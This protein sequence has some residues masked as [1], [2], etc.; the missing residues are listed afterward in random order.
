MAKLCEVCHQSYPDDQ[1]T[2]PHCGAESKSKESID[3]ERP[4]GGPG[5]SEA[6]S[7]QSM[8]RRAVPTHLA[9]GSDQPGPPGEAREGSPKVTKIA[10]RQAAQTQLGKAE[11]EGKRRPATQMAQPDE[12]SG[13]KRRTDVVPADAAG[14]QTP[15]KPAAGEGAAGQDMDHIFAGTPAEGEPGA[16]EPISS[17]PEMDLDDLIRTEQMMA[18]SSAVDLGS[19]PEVEFAGDPSSEVELQ[20]GTRRSRKRT[21]DEE[22]DEIS[23]SDLL[24]EGASGVDI[25]KDAAEAPAGASP[26][27]EALEVY[28]EADEGVEATTVHEEGGAVRPESPEEQTDLHESDLAAA[29]TEEAD[30]DEVMT[31]LHGPGGAPAEAGEE[32]AVEDVA[33]EDLAEPQAKAKKEK[34]PVMAG[35]AVSW[36]G[37]GVIGAVAATVVFALL[38]FTGML[39]ALTEKPVATVG[40]A[41]G[42]PPGPGAQSPGGQVSAEDPQ[43]AGRRQLETGDY[44]AAVTNLKQVEPTAQNAVALGEAQWLSYLQQQRRNN[45]ALDGNANEVK[46]ARE[47]LQKSNTAVGLYWVGKIQEETGDLNGARKTYQDGL[48]KYAA[49][50]WMFQSA[51]DRLDSQ[52]AA[53]A[54]AGEGGARLPRPEAEAEVAAHLTLLLIALQAAAPAP[55]AAPGEAGAKFWE[56]LRLANKERNYAAAIQ[57]LNQALDYHNRH[58]YERLGKAQNPI[59]DRYEDIFLRSGE[60]LKAYWQ[61][62]ARLSAMGPDLAKQDPAKA[63]DALVADKKAADDALAEAAKP[64]LDRKVIKEGDPPAKAVPAGIAALTKAMDSAEEAR[65]KAD[66]ARETE[67]EARKAAETKL[68]DVSQRLAGVGVKETDPVKGVAELATAKETL[69]KVAQRLAPT[70]LDPKTNLLDPAGRTAL[71]SGLDHLKQA[72]SFPLGTAIDIW[73]AVLQDRDRKDVLDQAVRDGQAVAADARANADAKAKGRFVEGLAL[74]NQGQF[75]A[76]RKRLKAALDGEGKG[77]WKTAAQKALQELTDPSAYYLAR[78]MELLASG[79]GARAVA[80]LDEGLSAELFANNGRLLALRSQARLQQAR[81]EAKGKKLTADTPGVKEAAEDAKAAVEAGRKANDA[82]ALADGHYAQGQI[83]ENLGNWPEAQKS[84]AAALDALKQAGG[85]AAKARASGRCQVALARVLLRLSQGAP[86]GAEEPAPDRTA[87]PRVGLRSLSRGIVL[88]SATLLAC[89]DRAVLNPCPPALDVPPAL[90]PIPAVRELPISSPGAAGPRGQTDAESARRADEALRLADAAI[91]AG[92]PE[93]YLVKAFALARREDWTEALLTYVKGLDAIVRPPRYPARY[94]DYIHGLDYLVKNAPAF[95]ASATVATARQS[96]GPEAVQATNEAIRLA[97]E[98]IASGDA[99]GYLTKGL[100]LAGQGR[101]KDGLK[102]YAVGLQ[103]VLPSP[104]YGN[105]LLYLVEKH[106]AFQRPDTAVPPNEVAANRHFVAGLDAYWAGDYAVAEKEFLEAVRNFDQDARY[107]YFLG[108]ARL[109]L[110]GKRGFAFDDFRTAGLL[111]R[112][113][114]P[115]TVTVG[116]TLERVQG[117]ARLLLNDKAG[118]SKRQP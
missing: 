94:V 10:P 9:S 83:A 93:A 88:A 86:I 48:Q 1:S 43:R 37:G 34:K 81:D 67:V 112:Q 13:K 15:G 106:P 26:S 82:L 79:H 89:S 11:E 53:G 78:P 25:D 115:G 39:T 63:I 16:S 91:A 73:P 12:G 14:T 61:I 76:A 77:E 17:L 47:N 29:S 30:A 41:P 80:I 84:Y 72:G 44:A 40:R 27:D 36:I 57:A 98:A 109:A 3:L 102:V 35:K 69:N 33:A 50:K 22:P 32:E 62:L 58:R 18:E 68:Q 99:E 75:D 95:Q 55:E 51:L 92:D 42:S 96:P 52:R 19:D 111:E 21:T 101:W 2:C 59:T 113:N 24:A 20:P 28:H 103:K 97:D 23:A 45:Q 108:L 8:V 7:K 90:G 4:E 60:E 71:L 85:G 87:T 49:E 70:Y 100:A 110:P 116:R 117:P 118:R 38:L 105:G 54:A 64:L 107:L 56:A 65:V 74:R 114:R 66:K 104:S 31:T 5:E 6:G 46:E